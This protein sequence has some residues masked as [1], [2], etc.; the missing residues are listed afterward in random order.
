[1]H[2]IHTE[3]ETE[4]DAFTEF[5]LSPESG[6][7]PQVIG[8]ALAGATRV[9]AAALHKMLVEG[10]LKQ[11]GKKIKLNIPIEQIEADI[12]DS[13]NKGLSNG[14]VG[15]VTGLQET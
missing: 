2:K 7:S 13:Y 1:M 10:D 9:V 5:T 11:D 12:V 3:F 4:G 14:T 8:Q 15:E 6:I